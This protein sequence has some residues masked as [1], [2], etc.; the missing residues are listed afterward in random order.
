[1][2]I[3]FLAQFWHTATLLSTTPYSIQRDLVRVRRVEHL[4]I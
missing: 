3:D 1:M 2:K 4:S